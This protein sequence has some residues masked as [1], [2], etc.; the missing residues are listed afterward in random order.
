MFVVYNFLLALA[1][2]VILA[3][4]LAKKRCRPGLLQ[5]LG[6]LPRG[7]ADECRDGRTIW[8]HAV[9]LGE[10][11]AVVP[12]VRELKARYP[13]YRV[14][15]ST[16]TETGK[17]TVLR[18]L[19]GQARHLYFPLDFPWIVDRVL[20]AIKPRAFIF[21]ETEL[22][23]N[24]LLTAA[25]R[26]VPTVLVNG[27]LSTNSF[28]GYL[29]F[30]PFF[31]RVLR[32]V[33]LCSMQTDRDAERIVRLGADPNRVVRTGNLKFDQAEGTGPTA[34][35]PIK[36]SDLGLHRHEEL[37]V[38]GST[39]P[40]EEEAVLDCYRRLLEVAPALVLVMAPRHIERAETLA[41]AVRDQ[42]F[43]TL[44]RTMLPGGTEGPQKGPRVII[45]D[46]RGELASLYRE[47]TLVFVG[48]SLVKVGGH[49]PLEPAAWGKAVVFGPHMD[50][51][52]EVADLMIR[53]GGGLQVGS[54][55]EMAG[56]MVGLLEDR[57]R[58][59][60]MGKA[61]YELVLA[62]QGAVSRNADLISG[63]LG[64]RSAISDQRKS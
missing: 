8:V 48:G 5:R 37:F 4:L 62:N 40:V 52:A 57:A 30:R 17:E 18:R 11:T 2:P 46:T 10:A 25:A 27:R 33:S 23:P 12:L 42:G 20:D 44:R 55:Q 56:A 15:V 14:F 38:A 29:R 19:E 63:I 58:L 6:R 9:S 59:E 61:A 60:K 39:H 24:F 43:A 54:A 1:F 16:V 26:G 51:F 53:Q 47:A 3:V 13:Q 34:S 21:V 41:G 31:E 36:R 50:H 35:S 22:W 45:L 64:E 32:T 28:Q 49:N 7:L